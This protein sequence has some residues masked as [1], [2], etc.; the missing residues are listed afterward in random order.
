MRRFIVAGALATLLVASPPVSAKQGPISPCTVAHFRAEARHVYLPW[1]DEI[2]SKAKLKW[3]ESCAPNR[4]TVRGMRRTERRLVKG[5]RLARKRM[6]CGS[7]TCNRRLGRFKLRERGELGQ[8]PCLERLWTGESNW[9]DEAVNPSSGAAGIPQAL[10]HGHVFNLGE[11]ARQ[12]NWGLDYIEGR[13]GSPCAA[14]SFWE[15][16]SPH[17]Y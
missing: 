17:W 1:D 8:W 3:L 10:G 12:I 16:Q 9:N 13:Y 15:A 7:P 6:L 4:R 11:P 14:L 5:R 2:G